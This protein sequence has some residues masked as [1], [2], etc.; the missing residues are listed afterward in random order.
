MRVLFDIVHPAHVH[1]FKH[2]IRA[3]QARGHETRIVSRNKDVTIDILDACGFEHEIVGAPRRSK[4]GQAWEL[5]T[6]VTAIARLGRRFRP[7][8]I[9]TRNP[10]GVQAARLIGARGVFDT[11]DGTAAGI[12]FRAA[13]PAAHVITTPACMAEDYGDKHVRY[14]GYKQ[15]AY[16]H[17][18]HFEADDSVLELLGV[19]P[20][21]PYFL[22]RFVSM[23]A[24]HD[25]G[26]GGM[27]LP[28]AEEVLE[29]LTAAGR[30]VLSCE[31]DIPAR[32]E[33][34]RMRIPP[35]RMHDALG[36]AAGL[37]GDSQTMAA[38]A[39]VLGVPN[40]RVSSW[41]GRLDYLVDLEERGLTR[42]FTPDSGEAFLDALGAMLSAGARPA[43]LAQARQRMLGDTANVADWYTDFLEQGAPARG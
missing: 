22:V 7:D 19:Q 16:L 36:F 13:Q 14:P 5:A 15:S 34:L 21:E 33:S 23:T 31:G 26:E 3:L 11:D 17:P 35:A 28:L 30:V 25:G 39:A 27:P 4:A 1:F 20:G 18:D 42:A 38:E 41:A 37:V 9:A 29:R 24:S 40:V 32:W 8:L 6:R 12:H 2:T 43:Q 10:S